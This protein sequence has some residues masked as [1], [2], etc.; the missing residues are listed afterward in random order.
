M[1]ISDVLLEVRLAFKVFLDKVQEGLKSE[2]FR[3]GFVYRWP[4]SHTDKV[5]SFPNSCRSYNM[6]NRIHDIFQ[7]LR[8]GLCDTQKWKQRKKREK[9][10]K[11]KK[12]CKL[13]CF[14]L[15]AFVKLNISAPSNCLE[16]KCILIIQTKSVTSHCF[17]SILLRS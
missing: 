2:D 7:L 9:T 16:Q 14:I 10:N 11:Q 5:K 4:H 3:E 1:A 8:F 12:K 13:N 17:N 6:Y 15:T